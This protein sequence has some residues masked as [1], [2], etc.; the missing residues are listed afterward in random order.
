VR[1]SNAMQLQELGRVFDF[2]SD[3]NETWWENVENN[4]MLL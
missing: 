1:N 3:P 2:D 4:V